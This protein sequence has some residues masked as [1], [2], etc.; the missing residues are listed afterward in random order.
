MDT[1]K[2]K[3]LMVPLDDYAVVPEDATLLDAINALDE[4]QKRLPQGRQPHRAV[5]VA[6]K[7]KK[8]VGKVGQLAFLKALEPKYNV[9]GDLEM[10]AR[11][12]VQSDFI[13]S[14][15][16]NYQFFQD[17]LTDLCWRGR[18][19]RVRDVMRPATE[20]IEENASLREAIHQIIMLQTLSILVT[21][22]SEVVGLLRLSDLYE[23]VAAQIK[24]APSECE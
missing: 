9:L 21:R 3:D 6:G 8:I 7:N 5:L 14:M 2:V 11:A 18:A 17:S 4:A 15:M 24:N 16:E 22:D 20:H 12:G 19:I 1:K 13:A 23:E 10:L